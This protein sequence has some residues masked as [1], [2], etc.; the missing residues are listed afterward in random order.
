MTRCTCSFCSKRDHLYPYYTPDQFKLTRRRRRVP[1]Q[2][3]LFAAVHESVHGHE[4]EVDPATIDV[5]YRGD[6]VA[7]VFL[8]HRSQIFRAVGA[9]IEY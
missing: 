6:C 9:A 3:T 4:T 2:P 1:L 5:C 8:S 7:K